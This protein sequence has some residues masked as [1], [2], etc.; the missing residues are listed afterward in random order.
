MN[1]DIK[2]HYQRLLK[3]HGDSADSAQ[4]SSRDSQF[5]RFAALARIGNIQEKR[6]L[7]FGCGTA[8]LY[9][10]FCQINQIPAYYHGVDI[11]EDF[12][13]IG[14]AKVGS[15]GDFS[16]PDQLSDEGYD[17]AFV[18]GVF[19]NKR[20]DNRSFWQQT[21]KRLYA[22]SKIGLAFNL[23]STYVDYKDP[24][25]YYENPCYAFDYVKRFITPYVCLNNDYLP[26]ANS[27]AFEYTIFAY[28]IPV[29]L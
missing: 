23:M 27:I 15:N 17:F 28:C 10:Y 24:E 7:D 5:R 11:V 12:F 29:S 6:V 2:S 14:R 1:Q 9:D 18:S 3:L 8:C 4:Y 25:L 22:K 20:Y 26:K 19:N 16:S 13:H 21:V